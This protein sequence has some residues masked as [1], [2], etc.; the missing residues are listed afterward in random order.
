MY[1]TAIGV[2]VQASGVVAQAVGWHVAQWHICIFMACMYNDGTMN[3][4][5]S[6]RHFTLLCYSELLHCTY[7][8]FIA[9][10][11]LTVSRA[12]NGIHELLASHG[13]T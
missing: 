7:R 1:T 9:L 8:Q 10:F 6:P 12:A 13:T 11:V 5:C 4:T 2:V 3:A